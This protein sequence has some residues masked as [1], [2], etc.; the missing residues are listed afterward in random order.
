MQ[1]P[2]RRDKGQNEDENKGKHV[3][4]ILIQKFYLLV[5][6]LL[7]SVIQLLLF[8]FRKDPRSSLKLFIAFLY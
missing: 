7:C 8:L 6:A 4:H 2:F 3:P 5:F 1:Q